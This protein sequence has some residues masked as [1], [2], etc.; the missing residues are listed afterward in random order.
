M[1]RVIFVFMLVALSSTLCYG[2]GGDPYARRRVPST[3]ANLGSPP[4][5]EMRYCSNC[6]ATSPC[7]SGGSGA[8]AERVAGAWNCSTGGS[9][10][11]DVAGPA[12]S[13]D[14]AISRFDGTDG[15]HLQNSSASVDDA[16][17][18]TAT[19]GLFSGLTASRAV[20]TDGSKNLSSSA[21]TATELGYLSGVTSAIQSQLG[22]KAN[23]SGGNTFSGDQIVG[24]GNFAFT[25]LNPTLLN[26]HAGGS[27]NLTIGQ[28]DGSGTGILFQVRGSN[29]WMI[30]GPGHFQP[31]ADNTVQ[32]GNGVNLDPAQIGTVIL[33]ARTSIKLGSK[34]VDHST[35]PT[36]SGF[37]TSPSV[38][39]NSGSAAFEIN[40]GTGGTANTGTITLPAASV[41]WVCVAQDVTNPDSFVTAQTGGTT[42][43]ATLKNYSRTTGAAIAWTASDILRVSCRAY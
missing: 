6:Q 22:L 38:V 2:Q 34:V 20:V 16:G 33:V 31:I 27:P 21:V 3:F 10:T 41:G 14:N 18:L 39:A 28:T 40:V 24:T 13:S 19:G 8:V 29:R 4:D 37:G 36:L 1:K 30:S 25:D 26:I 7:T 42:T 35:A 9:G 12:S 15:K 23:L 11:G 17:V 5:G 43:T 32:I